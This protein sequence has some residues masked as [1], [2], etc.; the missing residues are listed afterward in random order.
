M[1]LI[2]S[3]QN[4][5]F[6]SWLE[7][8]NS[9][10]IRKS[11][12]CI[13]SGEKL[14]KELLSFHRDKIECLI[15]PQQFDQKKGHLFCER[16]LKGLQ[17]FELANELFKQLDEFGTRR[18]MAIARIT[19]ISSWSSV[20]GSE[21]ELLVA[22]QDPLNLGSVIRSAAAFDVK[23]VILL[24]ESAHPFLPKA[25]RASAGANFNMTFM[26]GPSITQLDIHSKNLENCVI[27][28]PSGTELSGFN[29]PTDAKL[30]VGEE[31]P[32]VPEGFRSSKNCVRIPISESVESLN[33]STSVSIAL[34]DR[35]VKT[36]MNKGS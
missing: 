12:L 33:A 6:K 24:E 20:S 18:P 35:F 34:Y 3:S 28:D 25:T 2:T 1:E 30:L 13:V 16:D 22:L 29:W 21:F 23:R 31:G 5:K 7:L 8:L 19:K 11:E 17:C 27:L 14:V 15:W 4:N 10:G 32:G 26:R 9:R 36:E